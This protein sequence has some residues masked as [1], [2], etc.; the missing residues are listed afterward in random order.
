MLPSE[1]TTDQQTP[2]PVKKYSIL[3]EPTHLTNTP[4]LLTPVKPS[5]LSRTV[6]FVSNVVSST[7]KFIQGSPQ[8]D[9]GDHMFTNHDYDYGHERSHS[10]S[11][12]GS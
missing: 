11:D 4:I 8:S 6:N 2:S 10:P 1:E 12:E 9:A 7:S 5:Y 3:E